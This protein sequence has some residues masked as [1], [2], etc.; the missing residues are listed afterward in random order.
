[1]VVHDPRAG[2]RRCPHAL[3]RLRVRDGRGGRRR[4][5]ARNGRSGRGAVAIQSDRAERRRRGGGGRWAHRRDGAALSR[6]LRWFEE[7]GQTGQVTEIDSTGFE[8]ELNLQPNRNFYIT[9]GYSYIDAMSSAAGFDVGN[10]TLVPPGDRFFSAP[11]GD[12]RRQG[13]P[14]HLFNLLT[15][16]KLD[17]G[18]GATANIVATG[19][20]WNNNVGTIIIPAQYTL[21][22][23]FFYERPT[24]DAR[25]MLLNVTDEKNWGA[26]NGVYGNE[27][28]I[29]ELPFRLE[30]RVT[31]KF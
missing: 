8:T 21:D 11:P 10:T 19:D 3:G 25:V 22:V 24:W 2:L 26:P 6:F 20:I 4:H 5:R 12:I 27:S 13:A 29:A 15:T 18:F 31:Y 23:T 16:Y 14:Q 17:C 9:L 30:G 1:M 28:I 7:N